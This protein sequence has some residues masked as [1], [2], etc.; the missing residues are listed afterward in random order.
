M[1]NPQG[2]LCPSC[3]HDIGIWAIIEAGLPTRITCPHCDMRVIYTEFPWFLFTA[4][5][6][7][8]VGLMLFMPSTG[9][10]LLDFALLI[11]AWLPA[12]IVL[13]LYM[14]KTGTLV[15]KP[16]KKAAK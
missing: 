9:A 5:A 10:V 13:T 4:C 1:E 11:A 15:L 14:R 7:A 6:V 8:W 12:E 3:N 2:K 16:S